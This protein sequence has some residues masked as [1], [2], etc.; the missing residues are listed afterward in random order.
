MYVQT[1][2]VSNIIDS[3]TECWYDIQFMKS[4]CVCKIYNIS[5]SQ[6]IKGKSFLSAKLFVMFHFDLRN[7]N[8][9]LIDEILI[10]MDQIQR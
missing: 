7:D 10:S 5:L 3:L 6:E 9:T 2:K 1:N 8:S 4:C